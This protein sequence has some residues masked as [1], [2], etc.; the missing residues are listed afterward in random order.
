[1]ARSSAP[2]LTPTNKYI[3]HSILELF[4]EDVIPNFLAMLTFCDAELPQVLAALKE[5]G[6]VYDIIIPQK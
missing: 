1:M 2:R 5:P 6:S 3:L 4:G